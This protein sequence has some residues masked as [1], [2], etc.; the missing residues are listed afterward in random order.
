MTL[1]KWKRD[2]VEEAKQRQRRI[3][4]KF[5]GGSELTKP[6]K[7]KSKT[8]KTGTCLTKTGP[9]R[10]QSTT[11]SLWQLSDRSKHFIFKTCQRLRNHSGLKVSNSSVSP[12]MSNLNA[13]YDELPGIFIYL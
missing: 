4:N 7:V 8:N 13:T 12:L 11:N 1:L 9:R 6:S 3:S 10:R 5:A 2:T